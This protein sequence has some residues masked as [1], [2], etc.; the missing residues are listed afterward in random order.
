MQPFDAGDILLG[1]TLLNDPQDDHA[2]AGRI[3]QYDAD[4]Q[5]KGELWTEGGHHLVGGLQFDGNGLLWAFNDHSVLHVDSKT[6][7]QLP[8]AKF[9][10][11]AFYSAA[12]AADGSVYLGEHRNAKDPPTGIE[13]FSNMKMQRIPDK[14]VLGYGNIY[15]FNAD[16]ELKQE[17]D[18]ENAPEFLGFK[19]VTHMSLHPSDRLI[20]YTTETTKRILRYDVI[21]DFQMPDLFTCPGEGF[22]QGCYCAAIEYL[23]DGTLL[24]TLGAAVAML[25]EE[26]A[27]LREYPLDGSGWSHI[28]AC[29]DGEHA[30]LSNIWLGV[31]IKLHIETG[32]IVATLDTGFKAPNRCV[33]GVAEF[34]G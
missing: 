14:G 22:P 3:L 29:R 11:R 26:G 23:A 8:L 15:K 33:A 10:V 12:F 31:V 19:G 17:F 24:A 1:C 6:G 28:E 18:V 25:D 32:E 16:W 20:A 5:L 4:L 9:P 2:G 13:E 34:A 21:N 30:L 27:V 7:R